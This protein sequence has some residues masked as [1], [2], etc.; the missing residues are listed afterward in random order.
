MNNDKAKKGPDFTLTEVLSEVKLL[1]DD[2]PIGMHW[3]GPDGTILW[4]NQTELNL[5][6]YSAEEYIGHHIAD[7]HA[8]SDNIKMMLSSLTSGK[9]LKNHEASMVCKGG[10]IRDVLVNSNVRSVD[11]QFLHTRCF[12]IDLMPKKDAEFAQAYLASIVQSSRDAIISQNLSGAIT[13][14]N[15]AAEE[16]FGYREADAMGKH[17]SLIVPYEHQDQQYEMMDRLRQGERV[18][19]IKT[20]RRAKDGTVLTVFITGSPILDRQS[21]VIGISNIVR[22]AQG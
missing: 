18:D 14:W 13:S 12:T 16:L 10:A 7:F 15:P 9:A 6:G 1:F 2:A 4:A 17:L 5:L 22:R 20:A 8:S 3:V 11:G 19:E 21:R